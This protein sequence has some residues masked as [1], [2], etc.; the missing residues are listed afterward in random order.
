MTRYGLSPSAAWISP[1]SS[2]LLLW[3]LLPAPSVAQEG[4]LRG[5]DAFVERG[6]R[7]WAVPGLAVAV[8]KGDSVILARGYGVRE[9]GTDQQ[10]D[11]ATVFG[12]MSM[13]KAFTATAVGVLVDLG[14]VGWDDPVV[15]YLPGFHVYDDWVTRNV[16]VRDLLSHRMGVDRGDFLWYGTGYTRDEIVHH[17]RFLKPVAPFRGEYGYSN[18]MYIAAGQLMAGVTGLSWDEI[19]RRWIFQPLEM[20]SSCTSVEELA[21]FPNRSRPHEVLDGRLQAIPYRSLDNEAPGGSINSN[22][23]D[24]ARWARLLLGRGELEGRRVVSEGSLAETHS[25]QTPIRLGDTAARLNP[26]INFSAYGMGWQMQDYRGRKLLQHSGGI[27]GQRSRIALLPE[28]GLA[29]VV[30]TN[31]GR[32]N[33]LFDAVRNWVLDAYLGAV[34]PD[35]H[36]EFLAVMREQEE[37]EAAA[38][39]R[40]QA[41]RVEGTRPTLPLERFSGVYADSTYGGAQVRFESGAL[42]IRIGPEL[43]GT[44][45]HWHYNTFRV[46]W[47]YAYD[48]PLLATFEL[49]G[50]GEVVGLSLP[51]WWPSYRRV[52]DLVP[53]VGGPR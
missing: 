25:P 21:R 23:L 50:R 14:M 19:I 40:I 47:E 32:Q 36:A 12:I 17:I 2:L 5:L 3:A 11:S 4:P 34:G 26:G 6:L 10:V 1:V 52:G 29:V 20:H 28:E 31:R 24:M 45:E 46:V 42:V 48:Q 39:R 49:N 8:V 30:L 53:T 41:E 22:V 38:L 35:W 7:E 13:T 16:T 43:R 15:R 33:L 27:D 18:N 9:V 51:G 37:A 44:M